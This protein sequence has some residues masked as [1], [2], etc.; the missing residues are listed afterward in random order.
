[1]D[2][3]D[4]MLAEN[5]RRRSSGVFNPIT[6]EGSTGTRFLIEIHDMPTPR[7]WLP[8]AMRNVPLITHLIQ[9]G[10][11][12]A[13]LQAN[14]M[15]STE[16]RH[17]AVIRELTRLRIRHDFPFWAAAFVMIKNKGGGD[18]VRFR[19]NRPQRRTVEMLEMM[20]TAGKP[21]RLILLKARQWGGSTMIQMYMAWLQLVHKTG[22]NSLVVAQVSAAADEVRD[23]F[24][25]MLASYPAW[26]LHPPGEPFE[27]NEVK[28]ERVGNAENVRRVITRNCKIKTGSAERPD[29][30]RGGD[31]S[32][33]HCTEV[34]VW[35]KTDGKRPEDIVRS[36]CSGVLLRPLTMIVYES[37]A[38][39]VGNFFHTEYEAAKRGMSQ[40]TPLFI[41]WYEIEQYTDEEADIKE[42]ANFILAHKDND[43]AIDARHESGQYLYYLWQ[44][45]ATLQ[46]IAW[47][48]AER[49]K[50]SDHGDMAS[51]YPS[52][53]VE[54]FTFSGTRVFDRYQ[55][56][57]RRTTCRPPYEVGEI[58]AKD[59]AGDDALTDIHFTP[60]SQGRLQVW[61]MP[62]PNDMEKYDNRFIVVVDI[63]GRA[64]NADWSV[65]TVFDRIG[66]IDGDPVCVV[67]Q[68]YGHTDMDRLAWMAAQI[69][70]WY[71]EALLVIESNTVET[72]TAGDAPFLLS[73]IR[74][75]YYNLYARP[76]SEEDIRQGAPRKYG[77][78][79]NT[80][81]KPLAVHYLQMAVREG[82]WV[83]RDTRCIDELLAYEQK[84]NG[85]YGAI[86]GKHD[87]LLMTRA[88]AMYLCYKP[89]E[90]PMPV[91]VK[92][93]AHTRSTPKAVDTTI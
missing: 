58:A 8:V 15:S 86:D 51:E 19:L 25:R 50:Y 16:E 44:R 84:Q 52:D 75:S 7:L 34:G 63:G 80:Q 83:E 17:D 55:C 93:H 35:K 20:R 91:P 69:A 21:I 9:Y 72:H 59:V 40:F 36:A 64:Q 87:D 43:N 30:A 48:V 11:I 92:S 45:G 56:E 57:Q 12:T 62:P 38:N 33:V 74:D 68:W 14:G 10:S 26:L 71:D 29:S 32:L 73:Q 13:L 42:L 76:Q 61:R 67:A 77:F 82:L 23:M 2:A 39:G 89:G 88:I 66:Q 90:L 60:D 28:T 27:N 53:D 54:A 22:L 81:T 70:Y 49:M 6:G 1:M 24:D 37:T 18:D 31:Y 47:Y 78:H 46:A 4:N 79:T 3:V 65:I 41:P 85:S 5:T